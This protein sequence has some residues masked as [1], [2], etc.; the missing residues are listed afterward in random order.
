MTEPGSTPSGLQQP[1]A[2]QRSAG[3]LLRAERERQGL[4]V[5]ALSAIIKVAPGRIQALESDQLARVADANFTRAL[6]QTVCRALK[7]DPAPVLKA[8]PPAEPARLHEAH[9]PLNQPLPQRRGGLGNLSLGTSSWRSLSR[10][11]L[12]LPLLILLAAVVVYVLPDRVSWPEG[13]WGSGQP[14]AAQPSEAVQSAGKPPAEGEG[15]EGLTA[16]TP[17]PDTAVPFAEP[18][19]VSDQATASA[20]SSSNAGSQPVAPPSA[21]PA[22]VVLPSGG[23][24]PLTLDPATPATAVGRLNMSVREPAWIDVREAASGRKV[25]S[26]LVQ[27]GETLDVEGQPPLRVRVGNA[28]AVS[29]RYGGQ[30]I[31]LAP[32]TR[33]N[34][35]RLEL[36]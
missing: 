5:E 30:P 18:P 24:A 12:L 13:L 1:D 25:F 29:L 17:A 27:A 35:A 28:P 8:L 10:H 2:S 36:K 4:T 6:A 22:S 19:G 11:T 15:A 16:N 33:N 9:A 3:Q 21:E 7:I 20:V 23:V 31:D 32:H 26:R 34:V 14:D